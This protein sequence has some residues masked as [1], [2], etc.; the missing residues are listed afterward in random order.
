MG[1]DLRA[2]WRWIARP[3]RSVGLISALIA[4]FAVPAFM[5][6]SADVFL[7]SASDT[8]TRQVLDDHPTGLDVTVVATGRLTPAGVADLDTALR[9]QLERV[10]RL[11][12][13]DMVIYAEGGLQSPSPDG[14]SPPQAIIGSGA[15][16]IAIDG[17][18]DALD[19]VAGDRAVEGVWISERLSD[20]LE[21][22]AGSL[23]AIEGSAPLP[24]A[25]VFANLWEGERDPYWDA[26]P[27]PFVPRFSSFFSGP[28]FETIILPQSLF[29]DLGVDGLVRWDSPMTDRPETLD[30]L[31]TQTTRTRGLERSYTES[32]QMAGALA[33]FAGPGGPAPALGTDVFDLQAE[34]EG[35]ADDLDQPI[36]T[37]AIGGI[38]LGLIVTAAGAAF[39]VRKRE[40]EVRLLRADGDAAWRFAARA[41][42]QFVAPAAVGA[43]LGIGAAWLL[44]AIPGDRGRPAADAIDVGSI[45][46]VATIG[47]GVAAAI[48][49]FAATRVLRTRQSALASLRLTWFLPVIG[50]ALA[51]WI[52][53]GSAGDTSEV[54]PLV[55]AFPLVGLIAGVGSVVIAVRWLVRRAHRSGHS[56]P[57][58]LFL[59]WRRIS[60]ADSSAV[61]LSAALGVAFGLIVFS[62]SLVT[63]LDTASDAKSITAVG[64]V[65]QAQL[66]GQ[67]RSELPDATTQVF[68][69]RTRSTI[70]GE[71]VNV[72]A[73][74]PATYAN[75]VSWHPT[76]GSSPEEVV[77][78]VEQA[79]DADVAAVAAGRLSAPTEAGFGTN[80][81]TSYAVVDMVDAAPLTSEVVPTLLVSADQVNAAARRNHDA[82][83]PP[84]VDPD[85][86]TAAFRSP[87]LGARSVLISQLDGS[88]LQAFLDDNGVGVRELVT[89]TD[90]RDLIGNRAARWT[91]E[92]VSLLAVIGGLAAIGTLSFYLSEQRNNRQLSTVM[93]ERM[94]LRPRTSAGAA[95]L[96][97]LGLVVFSF[98][99][100]ASIA[101]VIA[102]RLFDR[103]DPDPRLA[104]EIGLEPPWAL[105]GAIAGVAVVAVTLAALV[106]QW[107]SGRRTYAEVLRGA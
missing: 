66:D 24:I 28:L 92:F 43:S 33:A 2:W 30:Q 44:I 86:W 62:S 77:A 65:S 22:P 35:V 10:G 95:I 54:D 38:G 74:D 16:L 51:A 52:Q 15:R 70:G 40:T 20:R 85:E 59:A 63:A 56:L 8:I 49:G 42:A 34:I 87:L 90:R 99:A 91:F 67:L 32:T 83:R 31:R 5:A 53:V 6:A 84:D 100:G 11:G 29:L 96:E 68:V 7:V 88:T 4:S 37:A 76:F 19:V 1:R 81:V 55:I 47:L 25:G 58:A 80:V 57:P 14:E 93:A 41:L 39:A 105:V 60:S 48:T 71:S 13:P 46:W 107:I 3:W 73:I 104:P 103:F 102:T 61:L 18:I 23:V 101:L 75:G 36:E 17:A 12:P 27:A 79:V 72:L 89:L 21:L 82:Q 78:A 98:S 69:T 64:G 97:V 26:I 50:V 106:N 94:G 45:A 9:E